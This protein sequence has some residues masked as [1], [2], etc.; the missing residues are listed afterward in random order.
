MKYADATRC[1]DCHAV[2]PYAPQACP[3]CDLPL[4]GETAVRLFSTLQEADRLVA[5]LRTENVQSPVPAGVGVPAGNSSMLE[6]VAP[7]PAPSPATQP[8]PVRL[9]AVSVPRILLTLGALCLLVAAVTFLAVAW[10]WLGVGGRTLV[11]VA[12]TVA[13]LGSTG[14]LLRRG[15]RIAA[16]ALSVVGLGLLAL[17]VIGIRNAGWVGELSDAH[18]TFLVGAVVAAGALVVLL[19]TTPCPLVAAGVIAPLAALVAGAGAQWGVHSPA[20][21]VATVVVLLALTRLGTTLPSMSLTVVALP[22][23]AAGWFYVVAAG[24]DEATQPLTAAHVWGDLAV[25]P[26]LAAVVLAAVLGRATGVHRVLEQTGL[27]LA[28]L[29]VSYVVVLPVLDNAPSAIVG[30]LLAVATTWVVVTVVA[31]RRYGTVTSFALLGTLVVPVVSLLQQVGESGRAVLKAGDTFATGFGVHVASSSPWAAA[32]LLV[33]SALV[34]AAAGCA[35]AGLVATVRRPAW[36]VALATTAALGVVA[37][38]PLYDVPLALVVGLL[39]VL[40]VAA[41]VAAERVVSPADHALRIGAVALLLTATVAALPNDVMTTSVLAVATGAAALLMRRTDLTGD[42][43]ALAFPVVFAGL[44]W[45]GAEVAGVDQ[46]LRAIPVLLVLGGFA[47]WRPQVELEAS[48]AL[49]G[50]LVSLAAIAAAPDQQLAL[51]VTLTVAGALVTTTSIVHESRRL[52]AWPGG[53]LLAAATWVRLAQIGVHTP[54]AYTL[55]SALALVVA[56][57]WRLRRDNDSATLTYL[58]PGLALATVP[59][60]LATLDD[61]ASWRALLLGLACLALVLAGVVLRWSAPLVVGGAVGALLVLR[62][63]APYAAVVPT[64]LVIGLSGTVLTVV[65]ITWESRMRDVRRATRYLA[66]LR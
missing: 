45:S 12:F 7:Y 42:A 38:L 4:T 27:A 52:L 51:A 3:A 13:S 18:L 31:P 22:A 19:S 9:G 35:V 32:W 24:L 44:A 40:A 39:T 20:P 30:S 55:P 53:L 46:Y 28:A 57:L 43:A 29:L 56:G 59:S 65:G 10:S 47:I 16:E 62:E 8:A 37:T 58:A 63:V 1:P 26:L 36:V 64:W 14:L 23:A 34:T 5:R 50:L 21:M 17:D 41:L 60:L 61:P 33:P 66:A 25:W 15:L 54:E 49:T 6:D 2:L 11:L 48:S